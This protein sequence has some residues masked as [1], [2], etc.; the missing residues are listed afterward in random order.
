MMI[1]GRRDRR[2]SLICSTAMASTM[3]KSMSSTNGVAAYARGSSSE[4]GYAT[5]A[6]PYPMSA[7]K[8]EMTTYLRQL[9]TLYAAGILTNEEFRAARGRLLGS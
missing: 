6:S 5:T 1:A 4:F 2:R 7:S 3:A 9:S 8:P